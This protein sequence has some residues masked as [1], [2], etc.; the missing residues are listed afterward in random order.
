MDIF[1][2][3]LGFDMDSGQSVKLTSSLSGD[4]DYPLGEG[5]RSKPPMQVLNREALQ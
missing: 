1:K 2:L 5:L 4:V 3:V